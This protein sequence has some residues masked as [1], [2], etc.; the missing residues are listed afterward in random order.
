MT[1]KRI[2]NC[3]T[4]VPFEGRHPEGR[5]LKAIH[6]ELHQKDGGREVGESLLRKG[7]RD[8]D[9]VAPN[10]FSARVRVD[11]EGS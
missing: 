8:S 9:Q 6:C 3:V 11:A 1:C 10:L 2:C 4:G 5:H 7:E